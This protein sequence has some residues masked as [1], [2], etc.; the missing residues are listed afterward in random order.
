MKTRID[1]SPLQLENLFPIQSQLDGKSLCKVQ[2][3]TQ[4]VAS[5]EILPLKHE[6]KDIP[7]RIRHFSKAPDGTFFLQD[8]GQKLPLTSRGKIDW[9]EFAS[10]IP[11]ERVCNRVL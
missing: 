7:V 8:T 5:L 2:L 1:L 3:N 9:N 4:N 10:Q 6:P 11:V